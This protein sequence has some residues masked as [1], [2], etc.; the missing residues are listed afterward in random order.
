MS[1]QLEWTIKGFI[2]GALIDFALRVVFR[3]IFGILRLS[4]RYWYVVFPLIGYFYTHHKI[5]YWWNN[6]AERDAIYAS[7]Q[8][9]RISLINPRA[10][11]TSG[12]IRF[13][14][15]D[16]INDANAR[17][18]KV[19]ATC[20][21]EPKERQDEEYKIDRIYTEHAYADHIAPGETKRVKLPLVPD[22]YLWQAKSDQLV[23]LSCEPRFDYE[24]DDLFQGEMKKWRLSSQMEAHVSH[25]IVPV[26]QHGE[27]LYLNVTGTLTNNSPETIRLVVILCETTN[28]VGFTDSHGMRFD[29][30]HLKLGEVLPLKGRVAKLSGKPTAA[31][32]R[33]ER[34]E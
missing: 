20:T 1:K 34:V 23:N 26:S 29:N 21:Y 19:S 2:I 24:R 33:F 12:G 16:V 15:F 7:F 5:A 27:S 30:L 6:E 25:E 28:T 17:I 14:E 11:M 10:I 18:Y 22:G 32:C 31:L 9:D 3:L 13:I 4:L 8:S